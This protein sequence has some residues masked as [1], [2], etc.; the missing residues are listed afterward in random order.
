MKQPDNKIVLIAVIAVESI[1]VVVAVVC[2]HFLNIDLF[3]KI[4]ITVKT[5]VIGIIASLILISINFV[6]VFVLPKVIKFLQVLRTAYDEVSILV[7]DLKWYSTIIIALFSGIAEELFFR[8]L[9]QYMVGIALAS[10]I[11]GFCHIGNRK[12]VSYGIYTVLIGFYL[13]GL[14]IYTQSLW[15]PI[16]VHIINNAVAIPVMQWHYKKNIAGVA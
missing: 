9:L 13:G 11:F 7:V 2:A 5:T 4:I 15:V 10:I 14:L 1:A 16:L 12:T 8:G 3:S 6:A